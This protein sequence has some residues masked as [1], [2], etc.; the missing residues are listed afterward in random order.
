MHT[1]TRPLLV[2]SGQSNQALA[3]E[4][5]DQLGIPLG[6]SET[7]RFTND[8]LVVRFKESLREA[9]VFI[10]QSFSTPVSDSIM[11]L[12]LMI[13]A[14]KSASAARV[15]A[16]VPYFSYARSDKKD[17]PR[18]SIAGRLVA[19]LIQAAGADRLLTMTLHS[20]QVHGFFKIPVDHLSA[21]VVLAKHFEQTVDGV[22][23]GVV[24]APDAGDI[25]RA[26]ALSRRLDS[27]LA[28]IDKRRTSD[29]TVNARALIGDVQGKKVYIVDDEI[30]TAGSLVE[31]VNLARENGAAEVYVAVTHGVYTGPATDRIRDLDVVEVCSTNTV[32]VPESKVEASG[33][34]LK[35]LT[36][37]P[38]FA[39]AIRHI[40]TGE[41]VS[42][43]FE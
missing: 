37:A 19:D 30:S 32:V 7:Q 31:A 42:T 36:V 33:G 15:T 1:N 18:I 21:E 26:S 35:T 38:L 29:T 23:D 24:L 12:L 8:N 25:K 14:A 16:V 22:H 39:K 4:I 10:V 28:F 20:P 43:L 27:G 2:F 17:E 34:K 40:H 5:C 41:S 3:Q 13:D 6:K 9:D 11:E